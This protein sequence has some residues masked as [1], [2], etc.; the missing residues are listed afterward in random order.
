VEIREA[1]HNRPAKV[2]PRISPAPCASTLCSRRPLRRACSAPA[3]RSSPAPGRQA[4]ASAGVPVSPL[5][6]GFLT[7]KIDENTAF[8]SS[9]FRNIVPRFTPEAR[10]ANL[11]L[12][13]LLA[14]IAEG[15]QATTAQIAL[16]WLLAQKPCI[17]PIPGTRKLERL[18]ENIGAAAVGLTADELR[19][20]E[21]AA[22]KITVQGDRYP[23]HLARMTGL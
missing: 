17:V 10:K 20:I 23:E 1:A 19:E 16:D 3:S 2:Q 9:D 15:K 5:G 6:K 22:S 4:H 8:D 11:A 7:G 13:D 14:R 21:S 12:V 18:E